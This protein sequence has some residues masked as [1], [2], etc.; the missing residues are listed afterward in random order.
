MFACCMDD[1][2]RQKFALNAEGIFIMSRVL[3][4]DIFSDGKSSSSS[5]RLDNT[6][7]CSKLSQR[8]LS[9]LQGLKADVGSNA[10]EGVSM[11][12]WR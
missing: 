7:V 6:Q 2:C 1:E 4:D 12:S 9:L 11:V 5:F 8:Q 10:S 3:E